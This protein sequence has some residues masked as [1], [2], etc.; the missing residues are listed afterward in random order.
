MLSCS[1]S[2]LETPGA[3]DTQRIGSGGLKGA[4]AGLLVEANG[5]FKNELICP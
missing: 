5:F 4:A 2:W 3:A 1:T